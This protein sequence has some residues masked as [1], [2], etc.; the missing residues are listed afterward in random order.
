MKRT[1]AIFCLLTIISVFVFGSIGAGIANAEDCMNSSFV[2]FPNPLKSDNVMDLISNILKL[3]VRIGALLAVF[4]IIYSGFLFVTAR[5]DTSKIDEAK[6]T[7]LYTVV[8]TA[9]LI[10]AE[11]LANVIRGTVEPLINNL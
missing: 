5:G 6:K 10:G 2:C 11:V 4:F 7:L 8:G 3:I 1:I 9:I